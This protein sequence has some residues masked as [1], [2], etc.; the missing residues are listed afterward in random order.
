MSARFITRYL[1]ELSSYRC[2]AFGKKP[3]V[4]YY[5]CFS[6]F[7]N[8]NA[9]SINDIIYAASNTPKYRKLFSY[10]ALPFWCDI[11]NNGKCYYSQTHRCFRS[12]YC[13][14]LNHY[15]CFRIHH[16]YQIRYCYCC[17]RSRYPFRC[18]PHCLSGKDYLL[19]YLFCNSWPS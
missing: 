6:G 7:L 2:K 11:R 5:P 16:Y 3:S 10:K 1:K 15:C 12:R 13:C 18:R 4:S 14:C 8:S 9:Y 17:F 19:K